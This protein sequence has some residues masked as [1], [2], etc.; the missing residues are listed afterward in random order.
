MLCSEAG[1]GVVMTLKE[2]VDQTKTEVLTLK[3]IVDL[4]GFGG[5]KVKLPDWSQGSYFHIIHRDHE[6]PEKFYGIVHSANLDGTFE[7]F[8]QVYGGEKYPLD[9]MLYHE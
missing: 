6:N 5:L 8:T 3:Q 2:F 1:D 7:N 4:N 9:W